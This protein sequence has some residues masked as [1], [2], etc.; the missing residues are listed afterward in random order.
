MFQCGMERALHV[1]GGLRLFFSGAAGARRVIRIRTLCFVSPSV[2]GGRG[3]GRVQGRLLSSR[4]SLPCLL[5]FST[6]LAPVSR[7]MKVEGLLDARTKKKGGGKSQIKLNERKREWEQDGR[8]GPFSLQLSV[9]HYSLVSLH[10]NLIQDA[11]W[12]CFCD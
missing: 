6:P 7:Q 1:C 10:L 5:F 11:L 3:R 2:A 9:D 12:R 4:Q 8:Y